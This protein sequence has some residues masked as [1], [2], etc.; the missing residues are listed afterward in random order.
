[1]ADA[2]TS[3]NA[4]YVGTIDK[5]SYCNVGGSDR[6]FFQHIASYQGQEVDIG[7][8]ACHVLETTSAVRG[9]EL[10]MG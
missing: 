2:L 3:A 6:D 1:M 8:V 4:G 9:A 7:W 10:V 5:F